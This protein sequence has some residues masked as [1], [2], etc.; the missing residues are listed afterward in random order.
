[1]TIKKN[2][3]TTTCSGLAW[4]HS[5]WNGIWYNLPISWPKALARPLSCFHIHGFIQIS[6]ITSSNPLQDLVNL[7]LRL[8]AHSRWRSRQQIT[9]NGEFVLKRYLSDPPR[10]G[11]VP[12]HQ[13]GWATCYVGWEAQA[14][15]QQRLLSVAPV[16]AI[17]VTAVLKALQQC[18]PLGNALSGASDQRGP[19]LQEAGCPGPLSPVCRPARCGSENARGPS[20]AAPGQKNHSSALGT[21]LSLEESPLCTSRSLSLDKALLGNGCQKVPE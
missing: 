6:I 9:L 21:S 13:P 7:F 10:E 5:R 2:N 19:M 18:P 14:A 17:P 11:H 20:W 4:I 16:T 12:C 8:D 3:Q 1:M 15:Q